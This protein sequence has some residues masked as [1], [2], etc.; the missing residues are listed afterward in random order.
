MTEF[1]IT[2]ESFRYRLYP[3]NRQAELLD[4]QLALCC[5][6]YNAALQ[7][8]RDAWKLERKSIGFR[9]QS[10]QLPETKSERSDLAEVYSQVLQDVLHRV[11][12]T[13]Q[14]FFRRVRR[15]EKPGFPRFRSLVLYDS[16]TYP[17]LGFAVDSRHLRLSKVGNIKIK[18]HRPIEGK[19]KTLTIKREAGRWFAAFSCEI[20]P[21]PLPFSPNTVGIDVGLASFATLSDGTEIPN[22]HWYRVG[23]RALRIAQRK[24]ARRKKGSQRRRKAVVLLQRAHAHIRQQR[25]DF[26]HKASR[27]IVDNFGLIAVEDLNVKGLARGILA[28]SVGDA[29]WSSFINKLA[30]KAENAGRVLVKVDPR[31][32]SQRSVCGKANPKDL[33]QRWHE[34]LTC[35]LSLPRDH[36][37]ALI[38]QGLGLSLQAPREAMASF[39]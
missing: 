35:G 26:Q 33:S 39:A 6:L 20:E 37:S 23:Q 11:D 3:S 2:R 4:G 12:K 18:L 15:R 32:T 10:D 24:V 38:I 8:R 25:G 17:Q 1:K 9:Q 5:E 16:M 27:R 14:S 7:E 21:K 29:G 34:C 28:K 30:Y 31:G 13:F 19:I 22:P 36:V